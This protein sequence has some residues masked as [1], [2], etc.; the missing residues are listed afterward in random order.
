MRPEQKSVR[1]LGVTRSKGKM[2]EYGLPEKQHININ[3]NP[4]RHFHCAPGR[5]GRCNQSGRRISFF[6]I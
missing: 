4:T 3:E 2:Y 5:A 6:R 1:L